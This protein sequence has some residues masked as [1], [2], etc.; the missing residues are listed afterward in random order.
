MYKF[1]GEEHMYECKIIFLS[2]EEY[3]SNN[4]YFWRQHKQSRI[5]G[6]NQKSL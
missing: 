4:G 2:L 1:S 6:N 3:T 5:G